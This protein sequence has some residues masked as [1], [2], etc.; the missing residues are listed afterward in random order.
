MSTNMTMVELTNNLS[1]INIIDN[2][3]EIF[4]LIWLDDND[5]MEDSQ[6]IEQKLRTIINHFKRFQDAKECQQYIEQTSKQD[7]ILLIVSG[8]LVQ[9]ITPS[10]HELRQVSSIYVY[11]KDGNNDEEWKNKFTKV[12]LY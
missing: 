12:N 10:I 3:L 7:R 8:Q 9:E 2:H 5:N 11:C 6:D 1:S 4:S